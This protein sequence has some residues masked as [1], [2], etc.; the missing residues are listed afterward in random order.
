MV[1]ELVQRNRL[2]FNTKSWTCY[3][4]VFSINHTV[5]KLQDDD[6][7]IDFHTSPFDA[8]HDISTISDQIYT[9]GVNC[10]L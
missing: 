1:L 6:G 3:K 8:H 9:S 7:A 10:L 5:V 2:P 4:V